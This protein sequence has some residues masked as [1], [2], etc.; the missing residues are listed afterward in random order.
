MKARGRRGVRQLV[1]VLGDQLDAE[2]AVWDDFAPARDAVWMAEVAEE[3]THVWSSQPR[4]AVF[5]AAMRHFRDAQRKLGRTVH[6]T[7][8]DTPGNAGTLAG[9]LRRAVA[10][11]KPERLTMTEAGDWRVEQALQAEA[12]ALGVPLE[13]RPDRHFYGSRAEF[14]AHARGRKQLRMEFFYREMRRRHRVLL[15][16]AGEPEGGQ[17][18][19]DPENRGSFGRGGPRAEGLREPRPF[20]SDAVTRGVLALVARRFA[21]HPGELAE[22]SWPVTREEA[23]AA[24]EDFVAHRLPN[25]GRFQ[26]AMWVGEPWLFHARLAAAMNL[27][28]IGPRE[29]VAAAERA[30]R[31][32]RVPLAAAEGFIRQILGWREYVRG[33]YWH[34][35]PGYAERNALGAREKLPEFYWTGQCGMACLRECV[36]QTLR[37]GYAHHIQRLMVTG[38]YALLLGVKPQETHAWYLSV[39]VDAVEWVELPNT[40]G[41]SQYADGGTMASKPY[42]ATGKYID[43][44]SNYCAGC[45]Y[46]PARA[47]GDEACPFTTLYWDFLLRHEP[48]LARNQRMALQVKNLVRLKPAERAAIRARADAIRRNG[49]E[50][51]A[52]AGGAEL[53]GFGSV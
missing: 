18:N 3:S 8:L 25:F 9:E 31:E 40:L 19:F 51:P 36:G 23:R 47:T 49:G 50:P 11:L 28:L 44:M 1:L 17:W 42:A 20:P 15:D 34:F 41:M 52:P 30:Y 13:V 27:K 10:E 46:D 21:G 29:I 7:E 48:L 4:I 53:P 37:Y 5:L 2:A 45:R 22:F 35:M 32:G 24:L 14:A 26:D 39:Y 6:Y 38:L 12:R 33:I 43:R 16:A